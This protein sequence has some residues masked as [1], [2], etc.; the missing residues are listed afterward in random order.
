MSYPSNIDEAFLE[1]LDC[2]QS[3]IP[4]CRH[5]WEREDVEALLL[6][7]SFAD[8]SADEF[9][10]LDLLISVAESEVASWREPD[11]MALLDGRPHG[12]RTLPSSTGGYVHSVVL[13]D[14]TILDLCVIPTGSL[15]LHP[16]WRVLAVRDP[17]LVARI[18]TDTPPAPVRAT[19]DAVRGILEGF[20]LNTL[21]HHKVLARGHR[22][23]SVA[24]SRLEHT[25]LLH[26]WYIADT[27]L[28]GG[29]HVGGSLHDMVLQLDHAEEHY[30]KATKRMFLE[31]VDL[32]EEQL[33]AAILATRRDVSEV[34]RRLASKLAFD[35]PE[36]LESAADAEWARYLAVRSRLSAD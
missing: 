17:D 10:D 29:S 13:S 32:A 9:S 15:E 26:L 1:S 3:V 16:P 20:W 23:V 27:G 24:G 25:I 35:Y 30:P 18:T 7:G 36:H 4:L 12:L 2:H 31:S 8:G 14:G 28:I 21:K 19:A 34:G 5:L 33:H 6:F 11:L 22:L